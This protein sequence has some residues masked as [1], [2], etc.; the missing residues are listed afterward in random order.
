MLKRRASLLPKD[1][2]STK[3]NEAQAVEANKEFPKELGYYD[4][5]TDGNKSAI[6]NK[7]L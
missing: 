3:I 2:I 1:L 5:K 7:Y 6:V 4:E